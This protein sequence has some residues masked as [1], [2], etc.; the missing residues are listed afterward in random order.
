[1]QRHKFLYTLA[2]FAP[3]V[4]T[5]EF[6]NIGVIIL[7]RAPQR[8]DFALAQEIP[9]RVAYFFE[10][11]SSGYYTRTVRALEIELVRIREQVSAPGLTN[12]EA[13]RL[14][15]EMLRP[16]ESVLRF[17]EPRALVMNAPGEALETLYSHYIARTET[18]SAAS[19]SYPF[20]P[21]EPEKAFEL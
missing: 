7:S 11:V 8:L 4:E 17:S 15:F 12:D 3:F 2:R 10:D 19:F 18:P 21:V 16:R 5:G 6:A 1:M 20:E 14:F 13:E 9:A